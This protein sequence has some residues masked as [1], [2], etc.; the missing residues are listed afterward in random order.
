V[1]KHQLGVAPKTT[2]RLPQSPPGQFAEFDFGRLG[3]LVE[4]Q[5]DHWLV[6]WALIVVLAFSRHM[7]VWP[8]I[9]QTLADIVEG[10]DAAWRF[11]AGVPKYLILD[12]C[13]AAIAGP[14]PLTPKLTRGFLEYAQ[15]RGFI[16][17]PTRVRHPQD[18]PH[19]ERAVPFVRERFFK[20]GTFLDLADVRRQ[21]P[22]WCLE[23]AGTRLHGTTRQMP[24]QVFRDQEQGQLQPFDA[25]PFAVPAWAQVQ[26]HLDHHIEFKSALY[27]VPFDRC[28]PHSTVEV[29][30][31][32]QLVRIYHRGVLIKTHPR[33]ERG[34]RSTDPDDYPSEKRG[35]ALR[36]PGRLRRPTWEPTSGSSSVNCS[37]M[38]WDPGPDSAKPRSCCAWPSGSLRRGSTRPVP[39][40]WRT[41]SPTC[42]GWSGFCGRRSTRPSQQPRRRPMAAVKPGQSWPRQCPQPALPALVVPSPARAPWGRKRRYGPTQ[43]QVRVSVWTLVMRAAPPSVCRPLT[44]RLIR[45]G[46]SAR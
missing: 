8:L 17:D 30:A 7:F 29:A 39:A 37:T 38:R 28:P 35:Y 3:P 46:R 20:G 12:N 43:R 31:D 18:K 6:V 15:F 32:S 45:P 36:E 1:A 33:Q 26:V 34:G 9:H 40:R 44:R 27:S 23:V 22:T 21:A 11:F 16:A 2:V 25:K 24:L 10:L 41:R 4:V 5:T 42:V 14:D 13:P 19:V